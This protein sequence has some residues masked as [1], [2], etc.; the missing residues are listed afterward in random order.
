VIVTSPQMEL[1]EYL[2]GYRSGEITEDEVIN[3][4]VGDLQRIKMYP[5][6]ASRCIRIFL[7][8]FGMHT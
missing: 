6:K 5:E 2:A 8:R 7:K 3:V 4:M 1:T